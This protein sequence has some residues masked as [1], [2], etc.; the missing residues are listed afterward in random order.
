V[1][2]KIFSCRGLEA[3]LNQGDW[4]PGIDVAQRCIFRHEVPHSLLL[5]KYSRY[6]LPE[7]EISGQWGPAKKVLNFSQLRQIARGAALSGG[8]RGSD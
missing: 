5:S 6:I 4:R 3:L 7:T 1:I 8:S 2:D